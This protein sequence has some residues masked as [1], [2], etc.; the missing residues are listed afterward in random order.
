[1]EAYNFKGVAENG[2]IALPQ[3]FINKFVEITVREIVDKPIRKSASLSPVQIDTR[4][5]QWSREEAN[6]RR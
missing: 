3:E 2:V 6:A 4:G 1:M 5:W